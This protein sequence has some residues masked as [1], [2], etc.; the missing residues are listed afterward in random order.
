MK[1]LK[2]SFIK[3]IITII[4]IFSVAINFNVFA[5]AETVY[6][7]TKD[8][9]IATIPTKNDRGNIGGISI[10][11]KKNSMFVVKSG[12][13][14][15]ANLYYYPN[16]NNASNYAIF[17][18]L[19][20]GHANSMAIDNNNV[21]VSAW[22][23]NSSDYAYVIRISR[24]TI[25]NMPF[26]QNASTISYTKLPT[27]YKTYNNSTGSY[28][29]S[30]ANNI[31]AITK[32]ENTDK[33]IV[34]STLPDDTGTNDYF[35]FSFASIENYNGKESFVIERSENSTFLV[36]NT[37][38]N[39]STSQDIYY[40]ATNGGLFIP[41]WDGAK[42]CKNVIAW[43]HLNSSY[44]MINI[45]GFNLK[46]YV[47]DK[48]SVDRTNQKGYGVNMYAKFEIESLAFTENNDMLFTCNIENTNSYLS[49]YKKDKNKKPPADG[50]F[51]L[52]KSDG[53]KFI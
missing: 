49:A 53:G 16:I 13:D 2:K 12:N 31:S 37:L 50:V 32:Y 8:T 47:P 3:P 9:R 4:A 20:A 51:K 18:L 23:N 25:A 29:Y 1:K 10:G 7:N 21:Y 17:S 44:S 28:S 15:N 5:S 48:I 33:F 26:N 38:K 40:S 30:V 41:R 6:T 42:A 43:A 19:G 22:N 34:H 14:N 39:N 11:K 52:T 36:K 24:S 35:I 46:C 45:N 27:I